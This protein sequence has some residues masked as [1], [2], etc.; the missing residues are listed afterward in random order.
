MS[1]WAFCCSQ[2]GLFGLTEIRRDIHAL[3]PANPHICR[4]E[5]QRKVRLH[6]YVRRD[7]LQVFQGGVHN[8]LPRLGS[9]RQL[10]HLHI[11][12]EQFAGELPD[13]GKTALRDGALP[14]RDASARL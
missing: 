11:D 6:V 4:A 1:A 7:P 2:I 14:V 10:R 12:V 9:A 13:V 8:Q 3:H 5:F